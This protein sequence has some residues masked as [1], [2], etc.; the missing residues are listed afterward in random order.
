MPA[1]TSLGFW[2]GTVIGLIGILVGIAAIVVAIR[3]ERRKSSKVLAYSQTLTT[4]LINSSHIFSDRL[5]VYL[6]G[7]LINDPWLTAVFAYNPGYIP[8]TKEDYDDGMLILASDPPIKIIAVFGF[9][10]YPETVKPIWDVQES[11]V[12]FRPFLLNPGDSFSIGILTD[13]K[14]RMMIQGRIIGGEIKKVT[15]SVPMWRMSI[16]ELAMDMV[17]SMARNSWY[18]VR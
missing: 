2:V 11:T 1:E 4:A 10:S 8:I 17:R 9:E 15:E 13:G 14:T 18:S 3:L 12:I 6:D 5:Q 7:E 16:S